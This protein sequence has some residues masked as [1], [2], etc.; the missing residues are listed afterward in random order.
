LDACWNFEGSRAIHGWDFHFCSKRSLGN[1]DVQI[2]QDII[3]TPA[4]KLVRRN[5]HDQIQVAIGSAII[6]WLPFPCHLI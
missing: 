4:E 5:P 2:H 3:L 1:V 6:T